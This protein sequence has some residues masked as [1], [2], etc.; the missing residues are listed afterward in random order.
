MPDHARQI[1]EREGSERLSPDES[2]QPTRFGLFVYIG[3]TM[4]V[5]STQ[6][7]HLTYK[8]PDGGR[9]KHFLDIQTEPS[10]LR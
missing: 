5:T 4:C 1:L 7:M 9:R 6:T 10:S 8:L 3:V 2:R